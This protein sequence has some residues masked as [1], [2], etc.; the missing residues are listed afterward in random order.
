M[1]VATGRGFPD[2][3]WRSARRMEMRVG[4]S[5]LVLI[6]KFSLKPNVDPPV[7]FLLFAIPEAVGG[8]LAFRVEATIRANTCPP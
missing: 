4:Q 7:R 3:A 6:L 8:K 1:V 5:E 2:D